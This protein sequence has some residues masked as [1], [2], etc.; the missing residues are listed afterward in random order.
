MAKKKNL[1][2]P[3]MIKSLAVLALS[4]ATLSV[5]KADTY[6]I[7]GTLT[8]GFPTLT[9][10]LTYNSTTALFTGVSL[11]VNEGD[12]SGPA[13]FASTTVTQGTVLAIPGNAN[14]SY[15]QAVFTT[16]GEA[17]TLDFS[18]QGLLCTTASPCFAGTN[19]VSSLDGD[20]FASG[21]VTAAAAV[22]PE[23]SSLVLL[24]TG[25]LGLAG[26]ARRKFLA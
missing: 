6:N 2:V 20:S 18:D 3:T 24:G 25:V 23:P 12:P 4:F 22:T 7:S 9:G 26:A 17:L 5:A 16:A 13:T 14:S 15:Y 10:T 21:T 19:A 11:L 1:G 8:G